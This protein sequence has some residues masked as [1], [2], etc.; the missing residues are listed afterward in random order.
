[1]MLTTGVFAATGFLAILATAEPTPPSLAQASSGQRPALAQ[2][3]ALESAPSDSVWTA[4]AI[5]TAG[6][7]TALITHETCHVIANLALGNIPH[8]EPVRFLGVIPF[9]AVS[10]QISCFGNQCFK[11]NG[12]PFDVGRQGLFL[13]YSAGLQCQQVADEII[14]TNEPRLRERAAPYL[15]GM[16]AFNTLTSIGYVFANWL[17]IEPP[18]G[19]LRGLYAI[20]APRTLTNVL[21]LAVAMMDIA[22]YFFPQTPFDLLPYASRAS[23]IA[24][25]GMVFT[26]SN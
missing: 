8:L 2:P 19:D 4:A 7:A 21:F 5:F 10:P 3:D 20:G 18:Y 11:Q 23:K 6:A 17:G 9:F 1:M 24:V 13:I 22:R 14:L 15:T 25:A 26:I 16:L 12:Q